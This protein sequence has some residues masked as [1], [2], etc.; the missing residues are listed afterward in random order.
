M[1]I[2]SQ[3]LHT[4]TD[5]IFSVTGQ[6]IVISPRRFKDIADDNEGISQNTYNN[7]VD[8][9]KNN[10]LYVAPFCDSALIY[11]HLQHANYLGYQILQHKNLHWYTDGYLQ[12]EI[13]ENCNQ[14]YALHN[15]FIAEFSGTIIQPT[16]PSYNQS[17]YVCMMNNRRDH[18]DHL[19]LNLSHRKLM[20]KGDVVYHERSFDVPGVIKFP[21]FEDT[22][23]LKQE[24]Y[25]GHITDT[26]MYKAVMLELVSEAYVDDIIF[27]TEK[28]IRPM[29]AGIP[30]I[31]VA[32][33]GYVQTLRDLGFSVYD[34][35]IDHSYDNE[36][37]NW[38]RIN[39][40]CKEL[41]HILDL[42][43]PEQFY[44][45]TVDNTLHNQKLLKNK[46]LNKEK[47]AFLKS[48]I[49]DVVN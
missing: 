43:T 4:G 47:D 19:L 17:R 9:L 23:D 25:H 8:L 46:Y 5:D 6:K 39:K 2:D 33:R 13:F 49:K 29:C 21:L 27:I 1:I 14:D 34:H 16:Q 12:T 37:D 48:W 40:V 36:S 18:R 35:I 41:Q 32:G 11:R 26:P 7:L 10:E 28:A 31:Y 44:E 45:A 42:Y 20:D 24:T 15:N 30:A 3:V 22:R 38:M